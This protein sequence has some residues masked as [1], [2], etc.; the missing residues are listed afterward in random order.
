MRIG[1]PT[2]YPTQ[3]EGW[4]SGRITVQGLEGPWSRPGA[5]SLVQDSKGGRRPW[6][7]GPGESEVSLGRGPA[8]KRLVW[9]GSWGGQERPFLSADRNGARF[10]GGMRLD[11]E[12]RQS[13]G[14]ATG[15]RS[16]PLAKIAVYYTAH[17]AHRDIRSLPTFGRF[18]DL[19]GC[20][21]LALY[22]FL[23]YPGNRR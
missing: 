18:T 1:G 13:L 7:W 4:A 10:A 16:G 12:E 21:F 8:A 20:N 14:D 23:V 15:A 9:L 6:S 19:P 22:Q 5:I 3:R 11:A 2:P 17:L